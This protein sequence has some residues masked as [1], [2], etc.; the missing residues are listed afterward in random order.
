MVKF[1]DINVRILETYVFEFTLNHKKENTQMKQM[2]SS[3]SDFGE[4]IMSW[5]Q[6]SFC[7]P[8]PI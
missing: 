3:S 5:V 2:I 7:W 8:S 4:N 6:I 1:R